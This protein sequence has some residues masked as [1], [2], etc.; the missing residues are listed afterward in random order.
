MTVCTNPLADRVC[1][2][3]VQT[4]CATSLVL[5][6]LS[7]HQG[8]LPIHESLLVQRKPPPLKGVLYSDIMQRGGKVKGEERGWWLKGDER[9]G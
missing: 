8:L 1:T 5:V 7:A 9:G 3:Y 4:T 6:Q 2:S